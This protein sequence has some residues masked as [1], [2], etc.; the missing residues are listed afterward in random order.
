MVIDRY[1]VIDDISP[2]KNPST[3]IPLYIVGLGNDIIN[4][5]SDDF[6]D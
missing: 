3:I 2:K 1:W 6:K 4:Q 5:P